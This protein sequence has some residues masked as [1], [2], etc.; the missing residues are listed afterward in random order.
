MS[1]NRE[2]CIR[3][4]TEISAYPTTSFYEARVI[5]YILSELD[6]LGLPYQQDEYGNVIAEY[7]N[8]SQKALAIVSHMDHPGF[9]V[10]DAT[11][12][13]LLGHVKKECFEKPVNVLV[14]HSLITHH[15]SG[16]PGRITNVQGSGDEGLLFDLELESDPPE[17]SFG[18]W[19][20][21][22]FELRGD[23]AYMR[24]I[25]DVVGCAAILLAL[26]EM[27]VRKSPCRCLGVFTRAEETGF[28]GAATLAQEK[29]I[30]G[31]A[32]VVS[33]ETSKALPGAEIGGGP[34]IRVGDFERTFDDRAESILRAAW[35]VMKEEN[36]EVKVQRQLMSGGRCEAGVFMLEGY[37]TTAMALPLGN[38]HNM[39][40]DMT[41]QPEYIHLDDLATCV[42]LLVRAAELTE[43][44]P[45]PGF[46][47][48]YQSKAEEFKDRL[49]G[50][51]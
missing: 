41:I 49:K 50:A 6:R 27:I 15:S 38:Y 47:E 29:I 2:R 46:R 33:L 5:A 4:L 12:G 34:V 28:I 17:G 8:P 13:R 45:T 19:D 9:E 22:P 26:E 3:A 36:P 48:R 44:D 32:I 25:D 7:G 21:P 10:L 30:P 14:F 16:I 24:A 20:L 18:M 1:T 31:D 35:R 40:E 11:H 51:R 23:L 42:E 39:G 37:L 43:T